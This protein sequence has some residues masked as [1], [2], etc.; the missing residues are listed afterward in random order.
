LSLGSSARAYNPHAV[1]M[2]SKPIQNT[3]D[4]STPRFATCGSRAAKARC[5]N[6]GSTM[7]PSAMT[8]HTSTAAAPLPPCQTQCEAGVRAARNANPPCCANRKPSS[9]MKPPY[10]STN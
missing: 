3:I 5:Q 9:S 8:Y 10:M 4:H 2:K 6:A 1:V 7:V